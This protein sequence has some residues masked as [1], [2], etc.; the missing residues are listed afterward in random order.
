MAGRKMKISL[1]VIIMAFNELDSI[2]RVVREIESVLTNLGCSEIVI[3]D[4]GSTDGTGAVADRLAEEIPQVRV[5]HHE[6]NRG[7]GEVYRTGFVQARGEYV[8]FFPADGQF[9][10]TII[11]QFLPLMEDADMV[12][13]YLPKRKG[14]LLARGLSLMEKVL[15]RL[16]FGPL[17]RFQGVLMFRRALLDN[18]ELKSTG[19][20]WAVLMEFIIR[21]SRDGYRIVT[22]PTEVCP[23]LSG[24]S[25]V[26]NLRTIW[27]NLK[28]VII[29]RRC[30]SRER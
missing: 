19:R 28:Q 5:I 21:I 12:L 10:A 30:L 17:P 25:K 7:L 9:P 26:N 27:A 3:I 8:T 29:L 23:R 20:G 18:V 15:Y 6:T 22:V 2:E 13:G 14:S 16:L 24:R 1:S 11:E 4:D